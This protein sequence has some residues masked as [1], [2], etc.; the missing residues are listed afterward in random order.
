MLFPCQISV[1]CEMG[2]READTDSLESSIHALLTSVVKS[3][4]GMFMEF[5]E[6]F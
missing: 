5:F 1:P 6:P 2:P 4:Q 3:V